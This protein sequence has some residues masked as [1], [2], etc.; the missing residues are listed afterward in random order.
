MAA[1][2][3]LRHGA[4][5]P[6]GSH[7]AHLVF[8]QLLLP[9]GKLAVHAQA[10]SQGCEDFVRGQPLGQIVG[11]FT[12]L[13]GGDPLAGLKLADAC[14]FDVELDDGEIDAAFGGP[15]FG[16]QTAEYVVQSAHGVWALKFHVER[17]P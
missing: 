14:D 4:S 9:A 1:Q 10:E 3:R 2:R 12:G 11:F 15:Q 16:V 17:V 8:D 5:H 6:V 13:A 7:D